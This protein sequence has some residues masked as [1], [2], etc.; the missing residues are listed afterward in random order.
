[1]EFDRKDWKSQRRN[2]CFFLAYS[3]YF[4]IFIWMIDKITRAQFW[5]LSNKISVSRVLKTV[6]KFIFIGKN[7]PNA[8]HSCIHEKEWLPK[9]KQSKISKGKVTWSEVYRKLGTVFQ[10][11]F[12]G[13]STQDRS[14]SSTGHCNMCTMLCI[15]EIHWRCS[16]QHCYRRQLLSAGI[17]IPDSQTESK[18]S[19]YTTT[20]KV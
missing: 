1:M 18:S 19:E 3:I 13:E 10:E 17:K 16:V 11:S 20:Y 2:H 9:R 8:A 7:P 6:S 5:T 12:P 15:R 14:D 4:V